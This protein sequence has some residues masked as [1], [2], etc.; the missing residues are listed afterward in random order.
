MPDRR[1][2][3]LDVASLDDGLSVIVDRVELNRAGR[4]TLGSLYSSF[5]AR[6]QAALAGEL[7]TLDTRLD[8]AEA[9]STTLQSE[10]D[11]AE[12]LIAA[13]PEEDRHFQAQIFLPDQP[14]IADD[15]P[16]ARLVMGTAV[17]LAE[18]FA[19]SYA[20]VLTPA[21]A[22]TVLE[23]RKNGDAIGT[24]TFAAGASTGTF[25]A[26]AATTTVRVNFTNSAAGLSGW[27]DVTSTGNFMEPDILPLVDSNGDACPIGL[28]MPGNW[29]MHLTD[30]VVGSTG[31]PTAIA[32]RYLWKGTSYPAAVLRFVGMGTSGTGTVRIHC[33]RN[34]AFV[35]RWDVGDANVLLTSSWRNFTTS[36]ETW[37]NVTP[38][39]DGIWLL[40]NATTSHIAAAELDWLG[41]G[42]AP[43]F[44]AGDVLEIYGPAAED[45]T[46]ADI[47]LTL[48]GTRS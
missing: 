48:V 24:V 6:V 26:S 10:I 2:Y 5:L 23:L 1:L 20:R 44:A 34:D 43:T 46:V 3:D 32:E 13:L 29:Q 35:G 40:S 25:A 47:S 36:T 31:L 22:E 38:D 9:I 39:S 19:G 27:N 37:T 30:G 4:L 8:S 21:T 28:V 33:T 41:T 17:E 16:L 11:A 18:G 42:G 7:A 12:A 15:G 45:E 14:A